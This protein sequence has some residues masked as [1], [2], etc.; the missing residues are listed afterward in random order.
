[1]KTKK[2]GTVNAMCDPGLD[3]GSE[4]EIALKQDIVRAVGEIEHE[5]WIRIIICVNVTLPDFDKCAVVNIREISCSYEIYTEVFM[6]K[7]DI[8]SSGKNV[9][10]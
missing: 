1:M 5:L 3:A 2:I 7:G 6:N 8:N 10:V 9:C 4:K